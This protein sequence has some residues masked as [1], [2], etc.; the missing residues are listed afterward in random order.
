MAN[1]VTAAGVKPELEVFDHG[2]L[3]MAA[4][5]VRRGVVAAPPLFQM[6][7]GIDR[8]APA[9]TETM[10]LMHNQLPAGAIWAAFGI[11][12]LQFPMA[13]QAIV[14]GG[15][16]RVGLEDNLYIS[17]GKLSPGNA[18]LVQRAMQINEAVG[19]RPATM[20]EARELL[21]L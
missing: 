13:A 5:M 6:C 7:L 4:D 17:Q 1:L 15:H 8:G 10:L 3:R 21:G 14:L 16:A 9:D 19:E 2:H 20:A 11:S 12:R 18:P